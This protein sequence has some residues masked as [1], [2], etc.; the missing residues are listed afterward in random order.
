MKTREGVIY[1]LPFYLLQVG[2]GIVWVLFG[3]DTIPEQTKAF[4]RLPANQECD[5]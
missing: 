1:P 3:Y 5:V 2:V 4:L